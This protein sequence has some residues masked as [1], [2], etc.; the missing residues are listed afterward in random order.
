M[1]RVIFSLNKMLNQAYP[2]FPF[3]DIHQMILMVEPEVMQPGKIEVFRAGFISSLAFNF[4]I[5]QMKK[6]SPEM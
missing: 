3:F 4:L 5:L 2:H 6:K 1:A